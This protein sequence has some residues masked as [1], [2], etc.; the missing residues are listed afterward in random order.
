VGKVEMKLN[1]NATEMIKATGIEF[2][3]SVYLA[4]E[5]DIGARIIQ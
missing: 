4:W 1:G 5:I 2:S 3:R